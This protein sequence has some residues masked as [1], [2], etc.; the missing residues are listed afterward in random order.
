MI[1]QVVVLVVICWQFIHTNIQDLNM[2]RKEIKQTNYKK[3]KKRKKNDFN[4]SF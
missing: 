2:L 1:V 3:K 4:Y